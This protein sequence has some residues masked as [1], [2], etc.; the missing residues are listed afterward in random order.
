MEA[1]PQQSNQPLYITIGPPC[2]GKTTLLRRLQERMGTP[3]Q[4]V[5]LDEQRDVYVP[6]PVEYFLVNESHDEQDCFLKKRIQYKTL[7]NRIYDNATN[8]ELRAILQRV[9]GTL[10]CEDFETCIRNLYTEHAKSS[11]TNKTNTTDYYSSIATL[12]I[13]TVEDLLQSKDT[14]IPSHIQ[15]FCVESLFRPHPATN[16]TGIDAAHE[17]LYKYGKLNTTSTSIAWGNT[18]TRPR[19]YRQALQVAAV[20]QRPVYF[21]V[22][23]S[24]NDGNDTTCQ[25]AAT[26][27]TGVY[28]PNV[29]LKEL[30]KR[31]VMRML[32]T[33]KF[34]PGRA[35]VESHDRIQQLM[36][37]AVGNLQ[38][39]FPDYIE[40][41][42]PF[43]KLQLDQELARMVNYELLPNR[44]VQRMEMN[45]KK[46]RWRRPHQQATGKSRDNN[47]R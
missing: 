33:G 47:S 37:T 14:P 2:A 21:I 5:T 24:D 16:K 12:V 25:T 9:N 27:S 39:Q 23:A 10:A 28:M 15:L 31:N 35:L 36:E 30:Y 18:N 22:H 26:T 4:D 19:E 32:R 38:R 40:K 7:E 29:G 8:G 1:A 34:V 6:V 45:K 13:D 44:T 42:E 17:E 41:E 46:Q 20:A 43:T 3:I 11:S